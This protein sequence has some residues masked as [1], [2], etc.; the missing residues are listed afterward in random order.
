MTARRLEV[1][2]MIVADAE[3]DAAKLEKR[4]FDA[5]NVAEVFGETLALIHGLAKVVES[6]LTEETS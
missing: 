5:R 2:R 6:L 1:V 3:A 4:P